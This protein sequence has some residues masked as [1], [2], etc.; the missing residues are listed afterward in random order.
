[1]TGTGGREGSLRL[2]FEIHEDQLTIRGRGSLAGPQDVR[3]ELTEFSR[4]ILQ[5]VVD[6]AAL[7]MD[8]VA[9]TFYAT[10]RRR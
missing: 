6:A 9:P 10:K 1:V 3:T 8:G 7:E 5:T 2:D 4:M